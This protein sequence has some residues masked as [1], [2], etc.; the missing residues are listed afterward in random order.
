MCALLF[1]FWGLLNGN[2]LL[3]LVAVFVYFGAANEAALADM[4]TVSSGLRVDAAMVT[5]FRAL[6]LNA[7]LDSAVEALLHTSQHEFP[8]IDAGGGVRGVCSRAMT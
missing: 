6:P 1:G 8:V 4:K 3:I 2:P 5:H 7:T